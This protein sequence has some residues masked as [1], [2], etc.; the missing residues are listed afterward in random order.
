ML[1]CL[2]YVNVP[3]VC[4]RELNMQL[5]MGQCILPPM[6]V[7]RPH[8]GVSTFLE[9]ATHRTLLHITFNSVCCFT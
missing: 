4:Q 5:N 8:L 3:V 6:C 9:F 7:A 2:L 1:M